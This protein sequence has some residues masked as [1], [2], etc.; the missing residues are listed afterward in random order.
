MEPHRAA[1]RRMLCPAGSPHFLAKFKSHANIGFFGGDV[2]KV[3]FQGFMGYTF[4]GTRGTHAGV[5]GVDLQGY[6]YHR[7]V[8]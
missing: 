1:A 2:C 6:M 5:Q 4:D 8:P 7:G 3:H